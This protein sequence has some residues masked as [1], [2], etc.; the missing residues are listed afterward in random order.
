MSPVKT[1]FRNFASVASGK[2]L[3]IAAAFVLLAGVCGN[4]V[5]DAKLLPSPHDFGDYVR[6]VVYAFIKTLKLFSL[7]LPESGLRENWLLLSARLIGSLL[8]MTAVFK[9]IATVFRQD[10]TAFLASFYRGHVVV[11]GFGTRNAKFLMG[12]QTNPNQR[13]IIVVDSDPDKARLASNLRRTFFF[14]SDLGIDGSIK[15]ANVANAELILIGAGSDERN[16]ALVRS[17]GLSRSS[18]KKAGKV[19]VTIDDPTL[20]ERCAR[21]PDIARPQNGDELLV[22]NVAIL[23][24]RSLLERTPF[25]DLALSAGQ[26]R[27]HLIMVGLSDAS[28]EVVMQFLR[29][30]PCTGLGRPQIDIIVSDRE[31][32]ISRMLERCPN[33]KFALDP[34]TSITDDKA[35]LAWAADIRIHEGDAASVCYD[36]VLVAGIGRDSLPTA[37]IVAA[38]DTVE[39]VKIGLALKSAMRATGRYTAPVYVRM[40]SR[41]SLEAL[42]TRSKTEGLLSTPGSQY[43]LRDTSIAAEVIEPFGCFE[44]ICNLDSLDGRRERVAKALHQ[45]YLTRRKT[46]PLLNIDGSLEPWQNLQETFRQANRRGADHLPVKLLSIGFE[47]WRTAQDSAALSA[48]ITNS[49]RLEELARLEH[50]SWRIDRELDGWRYSDQRDDWRMTHPDLVDYAML[51]ATS[52]D[53]DR[54]MIRVAAGVEATT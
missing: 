49:E 5:T 31:M 40:T 36:E 30:S 34:R 23:T 47:G 29:I 51:T 53:L 32:A 4:L 27:V 22:F 15:P 46:E 8:A 20:A 12:S 37:F 48:A 52:K 13:P 16:L 50:M 24:A 6:L 41:S 45:A 54:E 18:A 42:L 26:E 38:T 39:N 7:G 28:R 21:D 44:D 17:V 25:S 10:V 9:L 35:P 11:L 14:Q 3:G 19:V 43:G 1:P 33:L 2:G